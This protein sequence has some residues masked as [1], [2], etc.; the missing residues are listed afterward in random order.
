MFEPLYWLATDWKTRLQFPPRQ[1]FLFLR[2]QL[3]TK[4][5]AYGAPLP[6]LCMHLLFVSTRLRPLG[7]NS[8]DIQNVRNAANI[9]MVPSPTAVFTIARILLHDRSNLHSNKFKLSWPLKLG[10]SVQG[11]MVKLLRLTTLPP[12]MSRLSRQC[13]IL[14]ISQPCRL[15]RLVTG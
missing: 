5:E 15:P 10:N 7:I 14:N 2:H 13:G 11:R 1:E 9:Q 6:T 3:Q 4:C 12:S 8:K